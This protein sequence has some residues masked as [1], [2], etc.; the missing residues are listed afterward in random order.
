MKLLGKDIS[1]KLEDE[2]N[3][4]ILTH[5]NSA[6]EVHCE[7][8]VGFEIE[9]VEIYGNSIILCYS[10][11]SVMKSVYDVLRIKHNSQIKLQ[12]FIAPF[13]DLMFRIVISFIN[14]NIDTYCSGYIPK[15]LESDKERE[16]RFLSNID[17]Y[18]KVIYV[19]DVQKIEVKR[20]V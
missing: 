10:D 17:R 2:L 11:M 12:I 5:E 3:R 4:G 7:T 13:D 20:D 6:V 1:I 16:S 18:D 15:E 9:E 14:R 8:L 19:G